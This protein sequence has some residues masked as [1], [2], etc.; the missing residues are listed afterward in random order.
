MKKIIIKREFEKDH[1]S[2]VAGERLRHLIDEA[3][4]GKKPI[5]IDFSGV[6]IASTS[7]F[8]EGFAKLTLL[9]WNGERF[10]RWVRLEGMNAR[11]Q[12]VMLQVC[13]FRGLKIGDLNSK[14]WPPE[15]GQEEECGHRGKT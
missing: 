12:K 6:I 10:K 7:F 11:D 1:I 13:K 8:D 14:E 5:S 15:F 2:R 3:Y 9:G 4:R